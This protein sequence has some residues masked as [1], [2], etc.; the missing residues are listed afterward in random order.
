MTNLSYLDLFAGAGGWS[1]GFDGAGFRHAAMYDA[2]ESACRTAKENFGDVVHCVD[3]SKYQEID[4][5]EVD[6]VVGSPP[7]QGFSNEGYKRKHDPR[8][9]LVWTFLEVVQRVRPRVW[10]FEN[11]P[12]F[13]RSYGGYYYK[14][15]TDELKRWDYRCN[16]F[17]LDA[18]DYGV[19]QHRLRFVMIAARDFSPEMPPATH[20]ARGDLFCCRPHITLW[21]AISDL[22]PPVLGD[23]G[24]R[25]EYQEKPLNDYQRIIRKG[26]KLIL[27][28]TAQKHSERVLEKIRAVPSGGDMSSIVKSFSENRVHYCGGYRRAIKDQPSYTAYWTRGMTSIHP[29]QH[30]FLSPRECARIQSF[31]DRFEFHGR[32]IEN[33][34]QVCNAVPP[35]LANAVAESV[36]RQIEASKKRK[37]VRAP[38]SENISLTESS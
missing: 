37:K 29:T 17:L 25:F 9:N 7:C 4:F 31:P 24:G 36:M 23:R 19:P 6:V 21:E 14:L 35:L 1:V 32:T 33:Y 5:P 15:L 27:N 22:P 8:N 34:T 18:A 10:V 26:S 13:K 2:N 38:R 20:A 12:G 30:R 28:H 11:V 16:D 3:L